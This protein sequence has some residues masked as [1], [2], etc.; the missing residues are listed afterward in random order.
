VA[1]AIEMLNAVGVEGTAAANDAMN[2]VAFSQQKFGEIRTVLSGDSSDKSLLAGRGWHEY[3][4]KLTGC[5]GGCN[6]GRWEKKR[7]M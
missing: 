7:E 5:V 4:P 2:G 1:I 3:A 6:D